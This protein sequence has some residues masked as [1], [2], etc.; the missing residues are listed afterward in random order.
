MN[1]DRASQHII[2]VLQIMYCIYLA[3][4]ALPYIS[5][6]IFIDIELC[7]TQNVIVVLELYELLSWCSISHYKMS[8]EDWLTELDSSLKIYASFFSDLGFTSTKMLKFLKLKD[9]QKMPVTMPALHR[10]M[11]LNA[12]LKMNTPESKIG[13]K[14]DTPDSEETC[15]SMRKKKRVEN[16]SNLEPRKL[17]GEELVATTSQTTTEC[18]QTPGKIWNCIV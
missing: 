4:R 15:E 7:H 10:R 3:R 12:V 14:I 2:F 6:L 11:I 1:E 5:K 17:F 8:V 16:T 9:L 18:P 13:Q